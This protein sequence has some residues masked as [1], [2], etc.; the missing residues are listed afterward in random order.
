MLSEFEQNL[1][2]ESE[3]L[4]GGSVGSSSKRSSSSKTSKRKRFNRLFG[5]IRGGQNMEAV[6]EENSV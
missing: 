5:G 2:K 6:A 4:D 1:M 3:E